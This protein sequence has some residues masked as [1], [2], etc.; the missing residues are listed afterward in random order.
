MHKVSKS[1]SFLAFCA[2][3][4]SSQIGLNGEL[5]AEEGMELGSQGRGL[6]G[7]DTIPRQ[8][9]FFED[10]RDREKNMHIF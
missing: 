7:G 5:L 9:R 4:A 10:S 1:E 3:R 8:V 2:V 6:E